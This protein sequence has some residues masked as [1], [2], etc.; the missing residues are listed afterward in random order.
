MV[1]VVG[2]TRSRGSVSQAG[3]SSTSP[4]PR[5]AARS[6]SS[7]SASVRVGATTRIGR[8]S[9]AALSPATT[10]ARA[11]SG[12]A[13]AASRRPSREISA[14]SAASAGSRPR[15]SATLTVRRGSRVG[16]AHAAVGLTGR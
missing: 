5:M 6:V 10:G 7:R 13:T 8:R 3:N 11:A 15:R 12:T 4:G 9:E 16:G 1:S 2:L 14:G